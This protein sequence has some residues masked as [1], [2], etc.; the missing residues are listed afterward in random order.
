M[1]LLK[2]PSAWIPITLSSAVLGIFLFAI[3]I[4][5][6]PAREPDEGAG[7]HLFQIW[8]VLEL[9]SILF[10]AVKWLPKKPRQAFAILLVQIAA[11]LAACAPVYIFKL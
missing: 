8:L 2:K 3:A 10:F 4:F 11:A 5:G 6:P 9:F 1:P 7:A